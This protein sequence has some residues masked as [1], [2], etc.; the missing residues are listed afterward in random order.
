[1]NTV[2]TFENVAYLR[3][4]A[5]FQEAQLLCRSHL[6]CGSHIANLCQIPG[7]FICGGNLVV[8]QMVENNRIFLH[9]LFFTTIANDV[10]TDVNA[11]FNRAPAFQRLLM[12]ASEKTF[13][14]TRT[15]N[16]MRFGGPTLPAP[17]EVQYLVFFNVHVDT[18]LGADGKD[19]L[20]NLHG[21]SHA[22][23][24]E[25][26]IFEQAIVRH[27]S[28]TNRAAQF[29]A[30]PPAASEQESTFQWFRV[31]GNEA[32]VRAFGADIN[33]AER[34]IAPVP[35][36]RRDTNNALRGGARRPQQQQ[37]QQEDDAA[38]QTT[39]QRDQL[40][41]DYCLEKKYADSLRAQPRGNWSVVTICPTRWVTGSPSG[42][43]ERRA[44]IR[45]NTTT[46]PQQMRA[47][48]RELHETYGALSSIRG[49]SM[50]TVFGEDSMLPPP[51]N[52]MTVSRISNTFVEEVQAQ[53][54][55][56]VKIIT[57]LPI[58][59]N[60]RSYDKKAIL[61]AIE[62]GEGWIEPAS[63]HAATATAQQQQQRAGDGAAATAQP[64]RRRDILQPQKV[65]LVTPRLMT[66]IEWK[67]IQD[68]LRLNRNEVD[69]SHTTNSM[70][71]DFG[72]K[73][74]V[75]AWAVQGT[76]VGPESWGILVGEPV[77]ERSDLDA[78]RLR[79]IVLVTTAKK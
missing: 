25:A 19:R 35:E 5:A 27:N 36:M 14:M 26:I 69:V 78:A 30:P 39:Q 72:Q 28:D 31:T 76:P 22:K 42:V 68:G 32:A 64:A 6:R 20:Y 34:R 46:S 17:T 44:T 18:R 61:D 50:C 62:S 7:E 53:H 54:D 55:S 29:D 10:Y 57:D 74:R 60:D 43:A 63:P 48:A 41:A 65:R 70:M 67:F 51:R 4:P 2:A 23:L 56:I 40:H 66:A 59:R 37:R 45:F 71:I 21:F 15:E 73:E 47:V 12:N 79:A 9:G 33:V 75:P 49:S 8:P 3:T 16:S 1:M 13:V 77:V 24:R 58:R 11:L 38:T 52:P